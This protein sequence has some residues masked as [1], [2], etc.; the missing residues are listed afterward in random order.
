MPETALQQAQRH[1]LEGRARLS[2][3]EALMARL[4]ASNCGR[5]LPA[6]KEHLERMLEF[7][8]MAERHVAELIARDQR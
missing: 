2:A 7:Q 3:Q 6:A 5:L 1:V 4:V 8:A